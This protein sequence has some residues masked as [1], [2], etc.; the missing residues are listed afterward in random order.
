MQ[1]DVL[2][3][4]QNGIDRALAEGR[5]LRSFE[6]DVT[7][8]LQKLGWWGKKAVTDS[9]TGETSV[10]QLGSPRRLQTIYSTNMRSA[11]AAGQWERIQRSKRSLPFLIYELGPSEVHRVAHESWANTILPVDDPWWL[12]H[13]APNG[14]GCK[15]RIRALTR[16]AAERLGGVTA[17]P[18]TEMRE[19]LNKRTGE[20]E[21]VPV[22][23]DP[24]FAHNPGT[25]R[26]AQMQK[27]V[28]SKLEKVAPDVGQPIVQSLVDGPGFRQF[29]DKPD[30]DHPVGVLKPA[31]KQALKTDRQV[32]VVGAEAIKVTQSGGSVMAIGTLRAIPK[33]I[34][35]GAVIRVDGKYLVYQL[36]GGQWY[37]AT[38]EIGDGG[39]TRVT[40]YEQTSE[41]LVKSAL[42][43]GEILQDF[44]GD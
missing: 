14:W 6:K 43:S 15:C 32:V 39:L 38:L 1:L 41:E 33:A 17:R 29:V 31:L 27:L 11:R 22:G 24:G 40:A 19:W 2:E 35:S 16:R 8:T 21:L 37:V 44:A 23:I 28:G 12:T 18:P 3:V 36:H 7:P 13:F 4:L 42:R 34:E 10:A 26:Q 30:G 20:V 25:A 9:V 5:T